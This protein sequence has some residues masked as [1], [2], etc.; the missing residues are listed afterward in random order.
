MAKMANYQSRVLIVDDNADVRQSLGW[1]IEARGYQVDT[2][3]DGEE[4]LSKVRH[5]LPACLILL[6]LQM[7]KM[8]GRSLRRKLLRDD[9][10][11]RVPVVLVSAEQNLLSI[12]RELDTDWLSK[13]IN[14]DDL[15]Q[16]LDK[17]CP[18]N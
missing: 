16:L 13:P 17:Y 7:P 4:A 14:Y 18:A 12:A 1:I 10:L 8:D 15:F 11:A 3:E 2:A 6:D 5:G 9:T